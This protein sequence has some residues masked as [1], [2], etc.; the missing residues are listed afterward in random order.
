MASLRHGGRPLGWA[1]GGGRPAALPPLDGL[2]LPPGFALGFATAGAQNEGGF[3]GPGEPRN[4]WWDWEV[5]GHAEPSGIATE[6][7]TRYEEDFDVVAALGC[8]AYNLS[9]EWARVQ[10]AAGNAPDEPPFDEEAIDG[11][12]AM[13]AAARERGIEPWVC[14][15]HF[16]HP[17][18]L[19]LDFWLQADSPGV[20]ARYVRE[21]VPRLNRRLAVRGQSPVRTWITSTEINVLA[22][23]TYMAG[24]FPGARRPL[25]VRLRATARAL[26]HLLAAHVR[27]YDAIHDAY[28]VEGW[29]A[30]QVS[31]N[32]FLFAIYELDRGLTDLLLARERGIERDEIPAYAAERKAAW[33]AAL[34]ACFGAERDPLERFMGQL[35]RLVSPP[36]LTAALDALYASSRPRKLDA[37]ATDIYHVWLKRRLHLPGALSVGGRDWSLTRKLWEDPPLPD[38]FGELCRLVAD[39]TDLPVWVMENGICNRVIDGVAYPRRDGWDRVRYLREHLVSLARAAAGG[40]PV[41]AY[42]HWT[43]YDNWEWGSFEPRFGLYATERPSGERLPHDAMGHDAGGALRELVAALT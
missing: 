43:L 17:R 27:A 7:W 28:A 42:L 24:Y 29:P 16:A 14:L 18:W 8:N 3:N 38:A 23:Q 6:S 35:A 26:D 25:R 20:F 37:L 2:S 32:S 40:V 36:H 39:G 4:N 13:L 9:I 21:L 15:H 11:Y 1:D 10:P 19:G 33:V 31:Q 5:R 30:P 34:D 41:A 22:L 12:A